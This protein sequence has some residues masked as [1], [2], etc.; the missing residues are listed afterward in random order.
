MSAVEY[1]I[2]GDTDRYE[3]C[4]VCLAGNNRE[5]AEERLHQML[6]NP[7]DND[8]YIM[9]EHTNFRVKEVKKEDCWWNDPF[10]C[11]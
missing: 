8:K 9:K 6:T 4:L 5:D 1:I 2:I 10:L 11:N 7:T 3:G